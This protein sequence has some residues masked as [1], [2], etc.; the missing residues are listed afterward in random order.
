MR[1]LGVLGYKGNLSGPH[2][3][4][5]ATHSS[6]PL[7]GDPPLGREEQDRAAQISVAEQSRAFVDIVTDGLVRWEGMLA[8][9]ASALDGVEPG[10]PIPWFSTGARD[11]A[12]V[13]TGPIRRRGSVLLDEY[14]VAAD[15]GPKAL[16]M[17]LPGPATFAR[18]AERRSGAAREAVAR[19]LAAVLAEEA[20]ELATAGCRIFHLD[21]PGVSVHPDDLPLAAET[22]AT[23]FAAVPAGSITIFSTSFGDLSRSRGALGALP[24]T[25]LGLDL[26]EGPGNWDLLGGIPEEKGLALG[27]FDARSEQVEDADDVLKRLAPYRDILMTHDVIVGSHAGL[28]GLARDAAFEHL[29]HARYL[30]EGFAR[31][32]GWGP[33]A[34]RR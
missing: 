14:R 26:V 32:W 28:A 27:L 13:V 29:L 23:I 12:P 5:A 18:L 4:R 17:V 33:A 22:A 34:R 1:R 11:R 21:E 3:I 6:F 15:V 19:E 16:K 8:R 9:F 2:V 24:G 10:P 31:E 25:H 20:S 7:D 30:V